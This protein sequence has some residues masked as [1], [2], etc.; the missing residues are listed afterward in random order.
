MGRR[1]S[2]AVL[3]SRQVPGGL[4]LHESHRA[5]RKLTGYRGKAVKAA[6]Q[7]LRDHIGGTGCVF[8]AIR[9]LVSLAAIVAIWISAAADGLAQSSD[10][11]NDGNESIQVE[12]DALDTDIS[13]DEL[14]ILIVPLT[15]EDLS[16]LAAAWQSNLKTSLES[17]A[18]LN[19][20]LSRASEARG[21]QI[22]EQLATATESQ[23][24]VLENY[25]TVLDGWERKGASTEDLAPHRAYV[26]ALRV[27]SLRT[28]DA[29]TIIAVFQKWAVSLDGGLGWL[30]K[31]AGILVA[32]WI[33]F[34]IARFFKRLLNRNMEMLPS[35][36][37]LLKKFIVNAV[38]WVTFGL[39]VLIVLGLF[40]INVTPLFAIFG[41]L[42]FILGFALQETLGNLASGL[43]IMILKPFD[44]GDYIEVSGSSGFVDEMSVDSTQIRTFDNQ[45][46]VVPNSKIWGDVITNVSA[47]PERRVDLVFGI[48]YSDSADHAIN[49]LRSLVEAH[50]MCLKKP[51]PK[52]FVGELGDNSVNVFC[53]PWCKSDD[54]WT[55]YWDL[56][57]QAKERFDHEGISIPF[58]QRDVHLISDA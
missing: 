15:A 21:E 4:G 49:V 20:Q 37:D 33:V 18:V 23:S 8:K 50:P 40:G 12:L 44:T 36:S 17:F 3:T 29:R 2:R 51:V 54:Y 38:Y 1:G 56:T 7:N 31:L 43:M 14:T 11:L 9:I 57:G 26:A 34:L 52:I 16:E 6:D 53:R 22:R 47:S 39:G 28:T 24:S 27:D 25:V 5:E 55:V 13:N 45:I 58:P 41:G 19:L 46:I 35:V 48:A 32:F 30:L 42:S 10:T